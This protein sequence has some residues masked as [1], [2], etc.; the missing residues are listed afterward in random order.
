MYQRR[1]LRKVRTILLYVLVLYY[2]LEDFIVYTLYGDVF[3]YKYY[4]YVHILYTR[5]IVGTTYSSRTPP[6]S[7]D[8]K[9]I[10]KGS[11]LRTIQLHD[12]VNNTCVRVLLVLV[13]TLYYS[14]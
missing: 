2:E 6:P 10:T 11:V 4:S 7:I 14:L 3:N 8:V 5:T 12:H 9:I 1:I 13:S